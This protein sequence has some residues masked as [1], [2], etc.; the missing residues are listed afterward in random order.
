MSWGA[1]MLTEA[2]YRAIRA[3]E[4]EA[5]GTVDYAVVIVVAAVSYWWWIRYV[6]LWIV[7]GFSWFRLWFVGGLN[8]KTTSHDRERKSVVSPFGGG[9][10]G[11]SASTITFILMLV[12]LWVANQDYAGFCRGLFVG[13]PG[14]V[15]CVMVFPIIVLVVFLVYFYSCLVVER[16]V[17][18]YHI[19]IDVHENKL[20][21]FSHRFW[22]RIRVTFFWIFL[23]FLLI[24]LVMCW[25]AHI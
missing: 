9:V 7:G 16:G 2:E 10:Y 11:L 6:I 4:F 12:G 5:W 19:Y 21:L 25:L 14:I 1:G 13:I 23:W 20:S 17:A 22:G 3:A 8:E 24:V 15:M 18:L